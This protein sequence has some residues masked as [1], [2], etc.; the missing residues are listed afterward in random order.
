MLNKYRCYDIPYNN[1]RNRFLYVFI[2]Y[3]L[4][5]YTNPIVVVCGNPEELVVTQ[6]PFSDE[7]EKF[8]SLEEMFADIDSKFHC[9]KYVVLFVNGETKFIV[10]T[11]TLENSLSSLTEITED[12]KDIKDN[13]YYIKLN[14]NDLDRSVADA[15]ECFKWFEL[16]DSYKEALSDTLLKSYIDVLDTL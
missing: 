13:P 7:F 10:L 3:C 4:M 15:K 11:Q 1:E 9:F 14:P 8:A 5:I 6:E 2:Y 16:Y 12:K